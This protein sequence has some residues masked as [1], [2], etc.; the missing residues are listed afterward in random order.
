M[1]IRHVRCVFS[2]N[3]NTPNLSNTCVKNKEK[4]RRIY[5]NFP[6]TVKP[7]VRI[8]VLQSS[9]YTYGALY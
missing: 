8:I 9:Y 4:M 3:R 6:H 2:L 5:R 1:S 7:K